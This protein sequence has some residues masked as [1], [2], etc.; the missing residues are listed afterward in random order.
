METLAKLLYIED[1]KRIADATQKGLTK[2]GFEVET[3]FDGFVGARLAT[4]YAYDLI[5]LDINLPLMNGFEVCKAIRQHGL[6]T[7]ILMLTALGEIDDRVRGLDHGADDYLVK[8]FNFR[9]FVARIHALLRRSQIGYDQQAEVLREADL[10]IN[11]LTKTVTRSGQAIEVTAREY[12]ML[13]YML[14]NK[15][16]VLSKMDFVEHVWDLNFDTNTNIIEVYINYLRKKIDQDFEPKLIHTKRG[17]GY[18][19]KAR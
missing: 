6:D 3:A 17:L 1:D 7:P 9:E 16:R 2:E 5:I 18:V 13:E 15:G 19:L 11:L 12:E 14:R 10:E 8:P 4:T